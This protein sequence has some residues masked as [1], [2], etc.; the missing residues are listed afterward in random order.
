MAFIDEVVIHAK[1]GNGGNGVVRWRHEKFIEFAGPGGGDGG[2]GGNVIVEAV[3]DRTALLAYRNKKKFKALNGEDGKRNGMKGGDQDD[4]I[5]YVPTGSVVTRKDTGEVFEFLKEGERT[6][7]LKGG[8]GGYGN[9]HF[10]GS[11]NVTP[12]EHTDGKPGEESD[13][14]IELRLIADVGIVGLPNA[15]K[16]T[17]LNALTG[18]HAKVGDYPFTTLDPCI[19][20]F[21]KYIFADIPGLIEG[22]SKGRG[23]GH[24]FL[25]HIQRTRL[26]LQAISAERD[27]VIEDFNVVSKELEQFDKEIIRKKQVILITKAD[28]VSKADLSRIIEQAER[29]RH[30]VLSVSV[31]DDASVKALG[32]EIVKILRRG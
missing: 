19:G 5:L 30:P 14:H 17:L 25:R 20:V 22:A 28:T 12:K 31:L 27:S 3:A 24:K 7:L 26:I 8:R 13:L 21:Q 11:K 29:L 9:E 4:L 18:T 16:T 23:L 1:A 2:R 6:I 10:K 15:G 32:D